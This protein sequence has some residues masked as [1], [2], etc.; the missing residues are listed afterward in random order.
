MKIA[1]LLLALLGTSAAGIA[2]PVHYTLDPAHTQVLFSWNHLGY[3]HPTGEFDHVDGELV[4]DAGDPAKSSLRVS[5]PVASLHTHVPALDQQLLGPMYL[6]AEK[7][8]LITF[9]G[10]KVKPDGKDRFKVEGRLT[11]H[12]VT[13]PVTLDVTLNKAGKYPM[14]EAPALG[15]GA[16]TTFDRSAFGVGYGVPMV[17]D[18]LRVTIST[19]AIESHAYET[20]LLPM[21]Q[22][23]K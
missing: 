7:Y 4:Y 22:A 15:F 10:S 13:R 20:K 14:I 1:I 17:G 3:S 16:T 21:E 9:V 11:V 23:G 12:G 6:N 18:A 5:I 8:P 19:E 2:A